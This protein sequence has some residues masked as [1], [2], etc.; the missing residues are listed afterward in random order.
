ME[1]VLIVV[2]AVV[3]VLLIVQHCTIKLLEERLAEI[4]PEIALKDKRIHDQC[5]DLFRGHN[6]IAELKQRLEAIEL[7]CDASVPVEPA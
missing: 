1:Y 6:E 5:F 2:L 3:L 4:E 7:L